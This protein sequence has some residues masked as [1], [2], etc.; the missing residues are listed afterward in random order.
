MNPKQLLLNYGLRMVKDELVRA[1]WGNISL[2]V[3]Q[4]FIISPSGIDYENIREND[5]VT[6]SLTGEKLEGKKKP[7]SETPMHLEIYRQMPEI[8]AIVHTHSVYASA[9]AVNRMDIPPVVEDMIQIAGGDIRVAEYALPGTKELAD[10]AVKALEGRNAC[11][12]ANHGVIG[13]GRTIEEAYKVCLITEK[14]AHIAWV[15]QTMGTPV[16][17]SDEDISFM[18]DYYLHSYGQK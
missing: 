3:E 7:S 10:Y 17:L 18:V 12:L 13:I 1:N 11:L 6:L 14:S 5:L 16:R 2:R 9:F 4:G 8:C 15:S